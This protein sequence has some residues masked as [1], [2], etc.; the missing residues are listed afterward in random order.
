[1]A[2]AAA[3]PVTPRQAARAEPGGGGSRAF[4][5]VSTEIHTEGLRV[6]EVLPSS[7]AHLAGIR[8]GDVIARFEDASPGTPSDLVALVGALRPGRVVTLQVRRNGSVATVRVTLGAVSVE[9]AQSPAA[10]LGGEAPALVVERIAGD[11]ALDPASLRGRVVLV[12]FWATWCGPCR[13]IMPVLERLHMALGPRGLT[14]VGITDEPAERVRAH[15]LRAPVTY[16]TARD[17]GGTAWRFGIRAIPT[18]VLIDRAGRVRHVE[19]G[20]TTS[21]LEALH[22]AIERLLAESPS[23]GAGVRPVLPAANPAR[24]QPGLGRPP[25]DVRRGLL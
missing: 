4:L 1:V 17:V 6:V 23:E 14:V 5:G 15:L 22:G 7:P 2:L 12:D 21:T 19:T 20:P 25:V 9:S 3:L 11:A 8:A 24:P 10:L 13:R 16:T 18:L